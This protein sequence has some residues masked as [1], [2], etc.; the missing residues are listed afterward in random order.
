MSCER[1]ISD[2]PT[3]NGA[4][5]S[6]SVANMMAI[7]NRIIDAVFKKGRIIKRA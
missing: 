1:G 3:T 7:D 4:A 5:R 2:W 6:N